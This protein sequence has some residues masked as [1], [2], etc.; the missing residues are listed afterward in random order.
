MNIKELK[1]KADSLSVFRGIKDNPAFASLIRLLDNPTVAAYSEFISKL[2]P[3]TDNLSEYIRNLVLSDDNFYVKAIAAGKTPGSLID[4]AV[5]RELSVI[6]E[7]AS[8]TCADIQTIVAQ[9]CFGISEHSDSS[10]G[11]VSTMI[12]VTLPEWRNNPLSLS[13]DF[14]KKLD[15]IPFTGYGIYARYN[16]FRISDGEIVPVTSPDFQSLDELFGYERER[17]LV[18]KNTEA[19]LNGT[20]ASNMLLYGDMG[21]GKSSTIKAVAAAYAGKGLRI[22][23]LKKE[24]LFQIP[25]VL[26]ELSSNPLKFILF[27]DDLSFSG[28]DDNFSALKA[29]LEG[30]VSG[31]SDNVVIYATSN[32]RHLVKESF[33]D[34]DGDDLHVN[35]T[36]Q[37]T[38][39]LAARFGLTITFMRPEKDQ[40]LEIVRSLAEEYGILVYDANDP[41]YSQ[42]SVHSSDRS[43]EANPP[44]AQSADTSET[45][46]SDTGNVQSGQDS[47]IKSISLQSLNLKAEA[48][49]IRRSGRSPRTAK[50]FIELLRIGI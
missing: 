42:G 7:I 29:T 20:G 50:Q 43:A 9:N 4:N 6:E 16:F 21:T 14:K 38:M 30:S 13:A 46:G 12:P 27:I 33:S 23:E 22:I 18:I 2:Y 28:N 26:D 31:C 15:E 10:D 1:L 39:S 3:E 44:A 34:R 25:D 48:F 45:A 8:I 32:R 5:R 24:Q 41:K 47:G 37:E 40:Y 35:D 17:A 11:G 19:L 49:A 36:L